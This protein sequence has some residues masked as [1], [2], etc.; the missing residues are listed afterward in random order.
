MWDREG[1]V[2]DLVHRGEALNVKLV[3]QWEPL[4]APRTKHK[5]CFPAR[6]AGVWAQRVTL[7]M[8]GKSGQKDGDMLGNRDPL[9]SA[10]LGKASDETTLVCYRNN[11]YLCTSLF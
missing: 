11:P 9:H 1:V 10:F 5:E 3:R 8:C 4:M 2:S 6:I 7:R